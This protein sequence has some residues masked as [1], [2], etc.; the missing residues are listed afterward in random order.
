MSF[1]KEYTHYPEIVLD[2]GPSGDCVWIARIY[3]YKGPAKIA[4]TQTGLA[5]SRDDAKLASRL[6]VLETLKKYKRTQ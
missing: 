3:N 1:S 5:R 4:D 6:W 2:E